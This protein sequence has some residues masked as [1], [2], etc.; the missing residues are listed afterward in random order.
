MSGS[1]SGADPTSRLGEPL[2]AAEAVEH[3]QAGTIRGVA[4][5]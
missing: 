3:R 4:G 5:R 2:L 1:G